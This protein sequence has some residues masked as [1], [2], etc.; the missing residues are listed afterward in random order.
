MYQ[1]HYQALSLTAYFTLSSR[2]KSGYAKQQI[3]RSQSQHS[4]FKRAE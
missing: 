4:N 3:F 1:L 2:L